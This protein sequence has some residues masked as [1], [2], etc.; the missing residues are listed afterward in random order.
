VAGWRDN[1]EQI[2]SDAAVAAPTGLQQELPGAETGWRGNLQALQSG[3]PRSASWTTGGRQGGQQNGW[4]TEFYNTMYAQQDEELEK[5]TLGNWQARSD[6]TGI[7]IYDGRKDATGRA[8]EFGDVYD[9]G[10]FKGNILKG[11]GGYDE[12]QAYQVLLSLMPVDP[13][14]ERRT[15]AKSQ[16]DPTAV[17][18]TVEAARKRLARESE[19]AATRDLYNKNVADVKEDWQKNTGGGDA[20]LVAAAGGLGGAVLGAAAG[21]GIGALFGGIAAIPGA[22]IGGVLGGL[23]L[24]TAGAATAW[25]NQDQI[26]DQAARASVQT[27]M[28]ERDYGNGLA[29][30]LRQWG[31]VAGSAIA[32][33]TNLVQG[34]TDLVAGEV[35]DD[36]AAYYEIERD[37]TLTALGMGAGFADA[38][39]QFS[40][41]LGASLYMGTM[42]STTVGGVG[43]LAL[44]QNDENRGFA[45][46]ATFDDR[47][48]TFHAPEDPLQWASAIG[49]VGIDA[50]Q[51]GGAGAIYRS[52]ALLGSKRGAMSAT[53]EATQVRNGLLDKIAAH[54]RS[55]E[56]IAGR[57][58]KK[59]ADGN[60]ISSRASM[61]LLAPSEAVQWMSARASALRQ[62]AQGASL[63]PDDLYQAARQLQSG[64]N[65]VKQ[66]LING[67]AEGSEEGVQAILEPL[68]HGWTATLPEI[69]EAAA[70]GFATGAGMSAGARLGRTSPD[71]RDYDQANSLREIAGVG[72]YTPQQWKKLSAGEKAIARDGSQILD[73]VLKDAA[74]K[75][76]VGQEE[77][78]VDSQAALLRRTDAIRAVQAAEAKS[79]SPALDTTMLVTLHSSTSTPARAIVSSLETAIGNL[80]R[81]GEGLMQAAVEA[82]DPVKKQQYGE[83][84]AANVA[85]LNKISA[86][87]EIARNGATFAD[88]SAA[89]QRINAEFQAAWRSTELPINRAVSLMFSRDPQDNTNSGVV[90]FPQISEVLS[91]YGRN[92][93]DGRNGNGV[94]QVGAGI[95]QGTTMDFDGD[96]LRLRAHLV[97]DDNAYVKARNGST[98]LG[99]AEKGG[100]N[101]GTRDFEKTMGRKLAV[102]AGDP[103]DVNSV[104]AG[105]TLDT[106]KIELLRDL[107]TYPGIEKHV[108]DLITAMKAGVD[109]AKQDF[110]RVIAQTDPDAIRDIGQN[111]TPGQP[112]MID[113]WLEI[114]DPAYMRALETYRDSAA[115]PPVEINTTSPVKGNPLANAYPNQGSRS[116]ATPGSTMATQS[117][118]IEPIRQFM[119][120]HYGEYRSS[121]DAARTSGEMN[122]IR[123]SLVMWYEAIT[124][125]MLRSAKENVL[126]KDEVTQETLRILNRLS[127]AYAPDVAPRSLRS[128]SI[129]GL[130]VP[131]V[132]RHGTDH[133]G[134]ISI[135]QAVLRDVAER[136]EQRDAGVLDALP[137]LQA[138]YRAYKSASSYQAF[139]EVFDSTPLMQILGTGAANFGNVTVG[140][141]ARMYRNWDAPTREKARE[142]LKLDGRY[143]KAIHHDLPYNMNDFASGAISEYQIVVDSFI[144]FADKQLAVDQK[145]GEIHGIEAERDDQAVESLEQSLGRF[146]RALTE[147]EALYASGRSRR[148]LSPEAREQAFMRALDQ[149]QSAGRALFA[150]F[151]D[152]VANV[153]I[154]P[155]A[156][157]KVTLAKWFF[158]MLTASTEQEAAMIYFRESFYGKLRAFD[159]LDDT[160]NSP[161]TLLQVYIE[162]RQMGTDALRMDFDRLLL[163]STSIKQF[164]RDLN[165]RLVFDR[166]P[167]MAFYRDAAAFDAAQTTGGWQ[168]SQPGAQQREALRALETASASFVKAAEREKTVQ[169]GDAVMV[170]QM[171]ANPNHP[172]WAILEK[173]LAQAERLNGGIGP[174]EM[175]A[176]AMAAGLGFYPDA[177]DKGAASSF[178]AAFG[179]NSARGE[180]RTWGHGP[181]KLIEAFLSGND[182]DISRN[183]NVMSRGQRL[184]DRQ[185]RKITW[186]RPDARQFLELWRDPQMTPL[187]RATIFPSVWTN[188]DGDQ[189]SQK[190]LVGQS[191]TEL[192]ENTT[193]TRILTG[194]TDQDIMSYVAMADSLAPNYGESYPLYRMGQDL[195]TAR[196]ASKRARTPDEAERELMQAFR[197]V[198][199]VARR[200]A[201][202]PPELLQSDFLDIL[203]ELERATPLSSMEHEFSKVVLASFDNQV[204]DLRDAGASATAIAE[205]ETT[206]DAVGRMLGANNN[207]VGDVIR[208]YTIDWSSPDASAKVD[209]IYDEIVAIPELA[210]SVGGKDGE[211]V[212]EIVTEA[213]ER[214]RSGRVLMSTDEATEHKYWEA[215]ARAIAQQK[216]DALTIAAVSGHP[217]AGIPAGKIAG[218]GKYWDSTFRYLIEPITKENSGLLSSL[219]ELRTNIVG[220]VDSQSGP[221][222]LA[223]AVRA[224]IYREHSLGDWNP[225]VALAH[226]EGQNRI[227]SSGAGDQVEGAGIAYDEEAALSAAT[228]RTDLDPLDPANKVTVAPRRYEISS[229]VL[230]ND[231]AILQDDAIRDDKGRVAPLLLLNGRFILPT[232]S[233]TVNG[234]QISL[235][236]GHPKPGYHS[237]A[238]ENTSHSTLLATTIQALRRSIDA[239]LP[240][241]GTPYTLNVELLH[242]DDQ[243]VGEKWANN[244]FFEGV[245]TENGGDWHNSLNGAA[246]FAPGGINSS[247]QRAAL[248]A[249]KSALMAVRPPDVPGQE[250]VYALEDVNDLSATLQA[251]QLEIYRRNS[252][253]GT[254]DQSM[255]VAIAKVLKSHHAVRAEFQPDPEGEV[256]VYLFSA[257]EVLA[258]QALHGPGTF[259][260]VAGIPTL[261][262]EL[263]VLNTANLRTLIGDT[264]TRTTVQAFT[265]DLTIDSS[266]VR[267]WTGQF[268]Q[269]HVREVMPGLLES[270]EGDI[271][272]SALV[273]RPYLSQLTLQ[274]TLTPKARTMFSQKKL[275]QGERLIVVRNAR[276]G[277]GA[278]RIAAFTARN[279]KRLEEDNAWR[280]K[281]P[282]LDLRQAGFNHQLPTVIDETTK[283]IVEA[284]AYSQFKKV[285]TFDKFRA[286]WFMTA[287]TSITGD[288]FND[289]ILRRIEDLDDVR[290]KDGRGNNLAAEDGLM[291][292]LQIFASS[293]AP[294]VEMGRLFNKATSL[295]LT[296]VLVNGVRKDLEYTA[297]RL[298]RGEY[299]YTNVPGSSTIFVE[300]DRSEQYQTAEAHTSILGET[301][302][303]DDASVILNFHTR[304]IQ[305]V[306][307][308]S[309]YVDVTANAAHVEVE[310]VRDLVP[311][312]A[313][314][315]FG[316][317][318]DQEQ[319]AEVRRRL[320]VMLDDPQGL[321]HLARLTAMA[322]G[323]DV[324]TLAPE[325]IQKLASEMSELLTYAIENFDDGT[326]K[327]RVGSRLRT[328][329]LVAMI[330]HRGQTI[331]YRHGHKPP[332]D[333]LDVTQQLELKFEGTNPAIPTGGGWAVYGSEALPTA[334]THDLT[335]RSWDE[336]S[337]YGLTVQGGIPLSA[338]GLKSAYEESGMKTVGKPID[339]ADFVP[340]VNDVVTGH[341]IREYTYRD[342]NV[343]KENVPGVLGNA[344]NAITLLGA[345]FAPAIAQTLFNITPT[346][347]MSMSRVDQEVHRTRANELLLSISRDSTYSLAIVDKLIQSDFS[348]PMSDG[349][350]AI[351]LL[352][353]SEL[354]S[355]YN[356]APDLSTNLQSGLTPQQQITRAAI[357]YMLAPNAHPR[358]IMYSPGFGVKKEADGLQSIEMPRV[359][360]Q[361]FDRAAFTT[362]PT[363]PGLRA[364]FFQMLND[365]IPNDQ[366]PAGA[367]SQGY[368]L[369][370][371]WD[372]VITSP[373]GRAP[374]VGLLQFA[375]VVSTGDSITI[376]EQ[377]ANQ[378]GKQ[379]AS[380][381]YAKVAEQAFN[382]SFGQPAVGKKTNDFAAR[383][384][385]TSIKTVEDLFKMMQGGNR[386]QP[387]KIGPR[388]TRVVSRAGREYVRAGKIAMKAFRQPLDLS[389]WDENDKVEYQQRREAL[390]REHGIDPKYWGMVDGWVRQWLAAP[391]DENAK[392]AAAEGP[393]SWQAARDALNQITTN[394]KAGVL[395]VHDAAVP[396][397][398]RNDL[399]L[400]FQAAKAGGWAPWTGS[401]GPRAQTWEQ[402]VDVALGS[403]SSQLEAWLLTPT[404]GFLHTYRDNEETLLGAP[405]TMNQMKNLQLLDEGTDELVVSFDPGTRTLLNETPIFDFNTA[406][407][408]D[409][410]GGQIHAG[411]YQGKY[412]PKSAMAR[413]VRSTSKWKSQRDMQEQMRQSLG[414]VRQV[415]FHFRNEG[416][417]TNAALR[418][419]INVRVAQGLANPLLMVTAPVETFFRTTL[420]ESARLISGDSLLGRGKAFNQVFRRA[421]Q[422]MSGS[423]AFKAMVH[424]DLF[425]HPHLYNAHRLEKISSDAARVFGKA[426]DPSYGIRQKT[427]AK[428]YALAVVDFVEQSGRGNITA[429]AA[430]EL[431]SRNPVAFRQRHPEAHQFGLNAIANLRSIKAT[432]QSLLF[433][434]T[435]DA[436]ASNPHLALNVPTNLFLK[437]PFVFN[438]YAFNFAENILGVRG[439]NQAFSLFLS[440]N[441]GGKSLG[442][443]QAF[444]A[445]EKY[446]EGEHGIDVLGETQGAI[447][448]SNAF[449]RDGL[450]HTSLMAIGA[451]M[452]QLGLSGED[453]EDRRRKRAA[454]LQGTA[455]MD[456]PRDL[457]EDWRNV[458]TIYLDSIPIL[459]EWF[460]A[461]DGE[462]SPATMHWTI[463]QFVSPFLGI[464]KFIDTGDPRQ[465][466]WG[467]EDALFAMPL[468]N[469]M[470][471]DDSVNIANELYAAALD[472]ENAGGPEDLALSAGFMV[473]MVMG[474]ERML[475][476]NSFVNSLYTTMDKYDRD[477]WTIQDVDT[478]GT[479]QRNDFGTPME[480]DA[481][482]QYLNDAGEI[483]EGYAGRSKE[484]VILRQ[485]GEN[486]ATL[487]FFGSLFT[488]TLG[489]QNSLLRYDQAVKE[490][491]LN[492]NELTDEAATELLL[493]EWDPK[494]GA[495]ILT[496]EGG[497]A[498]MRGIQAGSVKTGDPSLQNV[499]ISPEQRRVIQDH[500]LAELMQEGL[501]LGLD[502][503]QAAKRADNV[504]YGSKTNQYAQPLWEI[505][506]SQGKF[507]VDQGGIEF[508]PSIKYQ[509]L[510]TTYVL[511]P[512]GVPYATGVARSSLY[513]FWGMAPLQM[514]AGAEGN[515][516]Q[517]ELLNTTDPFADINTGLRS[518][519]RVGSNWDNP[520]LEDIQKSMEEGF[521]DVVDAITKPS[522]S[523]DPYARFGG[524]GGGGGGGYSYRVNSPERMD[525]TYARNIPYVNADNPT[526]RR[527]TIR[528]ER[529][530]AERGRLNQWQ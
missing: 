259:P 412:P 159:A 514:F 56:T 405:L 262:H 347:W 509:Q 151:P 80:T 149:N 285:L 157:G 379:Q 302:A 429:E 41:G 267:P 10:Q 343:S 39:L 58:F 26:I 384:N 490:R 27:G 109:T 50:V 255:A 334:T 280:S 44:N 382:A 325:R 386:T 447:D 350:K 143:S 419:M 235:N 38:A 520:T 188:P 187:L 323:E 367:P 61:T 123:E 377:S 306:W 457:A 217:T 411:V 115:R 155:V 270:E 233:I 175:L 426:Q 498:I 106:L 212:R 198:V 438:N 421:T 393:V 177:T 522:W 22:V 330:D 130:T 226:V 153:L 499:F 297:G 310:N 437:L 252:G 257:E 210:D 293:A 507:A 459:N 91:E 360:T 400:L 477:P 43:Q 6:Y 502:H 105:Q 4:D 136:Y 284:K 266:N 185:G 251:K 335:I 182:R 141:A 458:D 2:Q 219:R 501:D 127:D 211:M 14:E 101:V 146:K 526:L 415:G 73:S 369:L 282:V 420:E 292:D 160:R 311:V 486:R 428:H 414:D 489:T 462:H 29:T 214:G 244:V 69:A 11:S 500:L 424:N 45:T 40:S 59:D 515:M 394:M 363:K 460:K 464:T 128:F 452:G 196:M 148:K 510:N 371:N 227:D 113:P 513:N 466:M 512:G 441:K 312:G 184:M 54:Q 349:S 231:D 33:T 388:A 34:V 440:G 313:Y 365:Q 326:G 111:G 122:S 523:N 484:E 488:G 70:M 504:W 93:T 527:A 403:G 314:D 305:G 246:Y 114:I 341:R 444:L 239:A 304:D 358:H 468:V 275:E 37:W 398:H 352:L 332:R 443:L 180:T 134:Y 324:T 525:V 380:A 454:K 237:P 397:M 521:Q 372:F 446:V 78:E 116:A 238:T 261:N 336:K 366:V 47:T 20:T 455:L 258:H 271:R 518:L 46:G 472:A 253:H 471:W 338:Y 245:L 456:D 473:N 247:E 17:K 145:T 418:I 268:D 240:A 272:T 487:G 228:R 48:G 289:G 339:E 71:Q 236:L 529:F 154:T 493:S 479:I 224:T 209:A 31:G 195:F 21:A 75:A 425:Q 317:P 291:I 448:F 221:K 222:D 120:L 407:Y 183:P 274:E 482:E 465:V 203:T 92:L 82:S 81:H 383:K 328:G 288:R 176:A 392:D 168:L 373:D 131:N 199:T 308:N 32:P 436:A 309:S 201:D 118:G 74:N 430:L 319:R 142:E 345:N 169:D 434:A 301:H 191:L 133:G 315:W 469:T 167:I 481:L 387:V 223:M 307:E 451:I 112:G 409:I 346:E 256:L 170:E 126:A 129:S 508:Q 117:P 413:R 286:L 220:N 475:L 192:L 19:Q 97:L 110:M 202:M 88:R 119:G 296:I 84:A 197:D 485:L 410:F 3:Q 480:T 102:A 172:N 206:A 135:A 381:Q 432:P 530:S 241:P 494:I 208:F 216:I 166:A 254:L 406:T 356:L 399:W 401:K 364:F 281:L 279:S 474:F 55:T 68:S 207:E 49:A 205:A 90:L 140:Q 83:I 173:R 144:G 505:V 376:Q 327:P 218:R 76:V 283:T 503:D 104:L 52:A 528:R 269:G 375:R 470:K 65:P 86:D 193:Y 96:R 98:V 250:E 318:Q 265:N 72:R 18:T 62:K 229:D 303:I 497:L 16:S 124:G 108:D 445:G 316:M 374:R 321:V 51:L 351:E 368:T 359:F 36:H 1:I 194:T 249:V 476:E 431:M 164:R 402:F 506:W 483:Q 423:Q 491:T 260:D 99:F 395:P 391:K 299:G 181:K 189:L 28:A 344:R 278:E 389:Q 23:G 463:K 64:A 242:P 273:S 9:K 353:A 385:I 57:V 340:P 53:G 354:M 357:L 433:R 361:I 422:N 162:L 147:F 63:Q 100:V 348:N 300:N 30:G 12:D 25:M 298:L 396:L 5:G 152:E 453:D 276:E 179:H 85:L 139:V 200:A 467:F 230:Q 150:A 79:A 137:E 24:G 322:N 511:G 277:Q 516:G 174:Q 215:A 13:E 378:G 94:L 495:E 331:L 439:A 337:Q 294:E 248:D 416:T 450:T 449:I 125:G 186:T 156:G 77:V 442:R 408:E 243:P 132:D 404:D 67:F 42:L 333:M 213:R 158:Q 390:L 89:T 524:G 342:D 478:T 435:V 35:G 355:Q 15:Y 496:A 232:V 492:R 204:S 163:T 66:A 461:G 8:V 178:F 138:K 519:E 290:S 234:Q 107:G 225:Y 103:T 7:S 161:D 295:G 320:Q 95:L 60:V 264:G 171:L 165:K 263:V 427:S 370:E 121:V 329:D 417:T 190:M 87:A 517:D 362:D 287:D